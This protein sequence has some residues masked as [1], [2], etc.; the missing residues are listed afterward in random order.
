[1]MGAS[2]A[3]RLCKN[4]GAW[5]TWQ[6]RRTVNPFYVGSNPTASAILNIIYYLEITMTDTPLF[7]AIMTIIGVCILLFVS[8]IFI[9]SIV[10]SCIIIGA[11]ISG[12]LLAE[13]NL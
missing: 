10:L 2:P 6:R 1:M 8:N 9:Y 13:N 3:V 12:F 5:P 4:I 11:F 7:W